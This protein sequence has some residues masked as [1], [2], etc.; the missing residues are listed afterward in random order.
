MR[1]VANILCIVFALL[2]SIV[3]SA[4]NGDCN[5][6]YIR[7]KSNNNINTPKRPRDI[8]QTADAP[9]VCTYYAGTLQIEFL[10]NEGE[11]TL[12]VD[13]D[14]EVVVDEIFSTSVP[15]SVY[16]GT[17]SGLYTIEI[18]TENALYTGEYSH[19]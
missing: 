5:N 14:G 10:E 9:V 1:I 12:V 18:E 15:H 11:A 7:L 3:T 16:I 2:L 6:E 17:S 4:G 19:M 13:K 8:G